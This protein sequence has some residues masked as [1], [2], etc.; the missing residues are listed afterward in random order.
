MYTI[1]YRLRLGGFEEEVF[2]PVKVEK[3]VFT[4][5]RRKVVE[6]NPV[7]EVPRETDGTN[8]NGRRPFAANFGNTK[9]MRRGAEEKVEWG[10]LDRWLKNDVVRGKE[11]EPRHKKVED[12]NRRM[13]R[14]A[15]RSLCSGL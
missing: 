4:N 2:M 12:R 1:S 10:E 7:P 3:I 8:I 13:E 9:G 5:G 14:R 11:H 15:K 6:C